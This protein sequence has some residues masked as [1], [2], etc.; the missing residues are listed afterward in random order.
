MTKA[1]VGVAVKALLNERALPNF[2]QAGADAAARFATASEQQRREVDPRPP[3]RPQVAVGIRV[4]EGAIERLVTDAEE[5][6][7]AQITEFIQF[8]IRAALDSDELFEV[9]PVDD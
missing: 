5:F 4:R 3:I 8:R 7:Q 6:I 9:V 1:V 2:A